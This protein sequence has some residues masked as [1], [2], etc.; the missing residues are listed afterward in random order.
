MLPSRVPLCLCH[1]LCWI[2]NSSS[3]SQYLSHSLLRALCCGS[4]IQFLKPFFQV[5]FLCYSN[6]IFLDTCNTQTV[7]MTRRLTPVATHGSL[8]FIWNFSEHQWNPNSKGG[9]ARQSSLGSPPGSCCVMAYY[10]AD[11]WLPP[12]HICFHCC[13]VC[14]FSFVVSVFHKLKFY[15]LYLGCR[16]KKQV[17]KKKKKPLL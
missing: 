13:M 7:C 14:S 8:Q 5:F 4:I 12:L 1:S 11:S 3:T 9:A 15:V 16:G 6:P 2:M 10:A 17:R